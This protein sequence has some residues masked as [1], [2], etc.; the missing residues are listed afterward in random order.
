MNHSSASIPKPHLMQSTPSPITAAVRSES[1]QRDV[2]TQ[3]KNILPIPTEGE[4]EGRGR[5]EKR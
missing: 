1:D 5:K 2:K 4:R 3:F